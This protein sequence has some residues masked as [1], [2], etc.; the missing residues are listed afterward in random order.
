MIGILIVTHGGLGESLVHCVTHVLGSKPPL[1]EQMGISMEDDPIIMLPQAQNLVKDLDRGA[2]VLVL[3]DIYGATPCNIVCR[4]M[5]MGKV[6][7]VAGVNL[8][9]L[10]RAL[11]YRH[12]ALDVVVEKA[13]AGGVAGVMHF[14][15]EACTGHD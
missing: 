6:E 13:V 4:L 10:I 3:S 1:L 7:G 5:Q 12:L 9:M 15:E 8:P 14:T 2:G 11:S